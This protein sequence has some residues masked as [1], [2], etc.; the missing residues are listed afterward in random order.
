MRERLG[1]AGLW[2]HSLFFSSC[3]VHSCKSVACYL[4]PVA[5]CVVVLRGR[6]SVCRLWPTMTCMR[7][8]G[9][10][11]ATPGWWCF[12]CSLPFPFQWWVRTAGVLFGSEQRIPEGCQILALSTYFWS[13]Q[14]NETEEQKV[15]GGCPSAVSSPVVWRKL[16]NQLF[17]ATW[18]WEGGEH[19]H[20]EWR[21]LFKWEGMLLR[22][23]R[24][25]RIL[26]YNKTEVWLLFLFHVRKKTETF[27]LLKQPCPRGRTHTGL[28]VT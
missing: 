19:K 28:P 11:L 3:S 23:G 4:P 15:S 13:L 8:E 5:P 20:A 16:C 6:V 12:C 14:V 22:T 18:G 27:S 10:R 26:C 17:G 2:S 21:W 24:N 7:T 1:S 25:A 9:W